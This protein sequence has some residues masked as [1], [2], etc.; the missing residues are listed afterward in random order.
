MKNHPEGK[1]RDLSAEYLEE[2]SNG[3][4]RPNSLN[5]S[6]HAF[7]CQVNDKIARQNRWAAVIKQTSSTFK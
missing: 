1:S 4:L 6:G 2:E 7:L 5:A 3:R